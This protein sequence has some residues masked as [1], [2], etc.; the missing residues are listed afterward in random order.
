MSR[1]LPRRGARWP[2]RPPQGRAAHRPGRSIH[3]AL[4]P[5][6]HY[7][8]PHNGSCPNAP[9]P[10]SIRAAIE[11]A[12]EVHPVAAGWIRAPRPDKGRE[13]PS[14]AQPKRGGAARGI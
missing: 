14:P 5:H 2:Q 4:N 12:L 13:G 1:V 10:A 8:P 9:A 3:R 7:P 11:V 6:H